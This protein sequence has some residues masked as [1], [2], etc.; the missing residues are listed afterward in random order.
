MRYRPKDKKVAVLVIVITL[1]AVIFARQL[2]FASTRSATRVLYTTK[3]GRNI[4]SASYFCLDGTMQ[5]TIYAEDGS[6]SVFVETESGML[7]MEILDTDGNT[8][9]SESSIGTKT[10]EVALD[11]KAVVRMTAQNHKG[12]FKIDGEKD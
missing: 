9:Y 4:W 8:V 11:G 10:F 5:K 1:T 7:S 3:E 2:G 12:Q 6:L